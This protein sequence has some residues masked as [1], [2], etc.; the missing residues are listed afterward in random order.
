MRRF[1]AVLAVLAAAA[2]AARSPYDRVFVS[3]TLEE[4]T[5]HAL[6]P[7]LK[8]GETGLPPAVS[9][10]DGLTEDEA[11]AVA[12]WNNAQFRTD[13][14]DLASARAGLIEAGL[15]PNPLLSYLH[16]FGVKGTEGY[17]LW[18]L[19][20]LWQR[21]KKIAAAKFDVERVAARL[22][23]LGLNLCRETIIAW[24]DLA[25]TLSA[26]EI[27]EGAAR[28]RGEMA[29]IAAARLK[30]GDISGLEESTVSVEA[31]RAGEAA[32]R[33]NRDAETARLRLVTLL[34]W[35]EPVPVF[36][37]S[38]GASPGLPDGTLPQL[39]DAAYAS[40]LDLRAAQLE[41][42][43]AGARLGWEKARIVKL[44]ATLESKE[45][46][47]AGAFTGTSG[48]LEIP[49]FNRNEGGRA[50]A[51]SEMERAAQN[52]I[53]V[54]Q[55]ISLEVKE[56]SAR[57]TAAREALSLLRERIV[58]A[59][60]EAAARAQKAYAVGEESYLFALEAERSLLDARLREV[61]AAS[62]LRRADAELRYGL[63]FYKDAPAAGKTE[64]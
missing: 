61:E 58:P 18:P 24:A 48:K 27:A 25:R 26:A 2:C 30:A 55:R 20:A 42:E 41:I 43:A 17:L 54:R 49:L 46:G 22:V 35:S 34:G 47:E 44:T 1:I 5:G 15:L 53:A 50:R 28:L 60:T 8:P 51:R 40:R 31:L 32:L 12:L 21:P 29:R 33:A 9:L 36:T 7:A 14:A 37:L 19:D 63:G 10:E 23:Q 52:Y 11:V 39:L 16:L 64:K 4:R 59:A 13:L 62:D 3:R 38:P 45:K 56:A 6:S 57:L